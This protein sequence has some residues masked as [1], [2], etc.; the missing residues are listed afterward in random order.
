MNGRCQTPVKFGAVLMLLLGGLTCAFGQD[1]WEFQD[2]GCGTTRWYGSESGAFNLEIK[3]QTILSPPESLS[4]D[5]G[6]NGGVRVVGWERDEIRI[7]ACIQA[8]G[9]T[10]EEAHAR[11]SAVRITSNDGGTIRAISSADEGYSFGA[12]YDIRVPVKTNLTIKT[13][14]GGINLS[15]I[16]GSIEFDLNNGGAIFNSISGNI[17][18]KTVN[19]NLNFYLSGTEREGKGIDVRTTNGNILISVPENYSA[20]IEAST[21]RGKVYVDPSVTDARANDSKINLNL[22]NGGATIKASTVNGQIV[23]KH[24][25]TKEASGK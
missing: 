1:K 6:Q 24:R 9:L 11:T 14:N 17:L 16:D 7:R 20:S 4:I 25:T 13:H 18:G 21:R 12:S 23:I 22:G 3:E 5:T 15:G 8:F 2:D 19:G 10:A